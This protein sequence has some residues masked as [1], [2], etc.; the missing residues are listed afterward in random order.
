MRDRMFS[1]HRPSRRR[2]NR[3]IPIRVSR[4]KL[5]AVLR[6]SLAFLCAA[7]LA[8]QCY[9]PEVAIDAVSRL[10]PAQMVDAGHYREAEVIL[11]PLVAQHPHDAHAAWLLSRAESALGNLDDAM[12]LAEA[13]LAEDASSAAYHVQTAA[14]AGRQAEKANL[15]KQLGYAKRAKQELDAALALEPANTDA[16]W[17]LMMYYYAAPA[18]IGGDKAKAQRMGAE[19]AAVSKTIGPYYEGRLAREMKDFDK[20]ESF[21]KQAASEDPTFYDAAAA[22]AKLYIEDKPDQTHAKAWACQAVHTDPTRADAWALLAQAYSMCGCWTEAIDVAHRAEAIDAVNV[23][24]LYGIAWVA[25]ARG[26]QL[27]MA[28]EFLR[29]YLAQP[30]GGEQPSEAAAH[31]QLGLALEE[32]GRMDEALAELKI[33]AD[34]DAS[35]EGIRPALKRASAA[36]KK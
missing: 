20:A 18:L 14:V 29:R 27:E 25:V 1:A 31:M 5:I 11:K 23:A 7:P 35:L 21:F 9:L 3:A 6:F 30:P 15:F 10:S 22:L 19:M 2:S 13:A 24:P 36:A 26:E 8:A 32:L 12:S 33:A 16:Q 28:M 34:Q 4:R 17:G